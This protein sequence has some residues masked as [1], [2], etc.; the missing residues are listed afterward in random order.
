MGMRATANRI[1]SAP[2][3]AILEVAMRHLVD[4]A[5]D[6]KAFVTRD[7][8]RA[9]ETG[10][11]DLRRTLTARRADLDALRQAVEA[12]SLDFGEDPFEDNEEDDYEAAV[13]RLETS[14]TTLQADLDRTAGA[15]RATSDQLS[16]LDASLQAMTGRIDKANIAAT[17]ARATAEAAADGISDLENAK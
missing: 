4:E 7:E 3:L 9:M 17:S 8:V 10:I 2:T 5:L 15:L 6:A 11:E 13:L 14:R 1:L 16:G 12:F